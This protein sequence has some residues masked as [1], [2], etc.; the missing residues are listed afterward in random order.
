[1][2]FRIKF[3]YKATENPIK[4]QTHTHIIKETKMADNLYIYIYIERES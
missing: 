1:M 3:N 4:K 2:Y